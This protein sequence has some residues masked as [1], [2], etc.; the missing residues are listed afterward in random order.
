MPTA[1]YVTQPIATSGA[2]LA[3]LQS[4]GLAGVVSLLVA[5]NPALA[6][7]T[8]QATVSV[9]AGAATSLAAGDYYLSYGYVGLGGRTLAGGRSA[10]FTIAGSPNNAPQVTLP[11]LPTGA[12]SISLYLTAAGGAA[13]TEVL[14]ATGITATTANLVSATYAD[15]LRT[16]PT[17]NTTGLSALAAQIEASLAYPHETDPLYGLAQL[18]S[19]YAEGDPIA[20]SAAV[21]LA[22]SYAALY[23]ALSQAVADVAGLIYANPGTLGSTA[24]VA[25]LGSTPS[26][27]FP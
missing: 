27:S 23:A 5:A 4:G 2:A 3:D 26:R 8:T 13:G 6:N 18:V 19:S 24:S 7:P 16:L 14:Y 12:A 9:T 1:S 22:T 25:G 20:V 10:K 21:D 15:P 11:T 17:V